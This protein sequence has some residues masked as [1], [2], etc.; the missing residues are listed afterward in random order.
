MIFEGKKR[1][2]GH[3]ESNSVEAD[4][5]PKYVMEF[6]IR[7]ITQLISFFLTLKFAMNRFLIQL[8]N[9]NGLITENLSLWLTPLKMGAKTIP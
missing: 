5:V 8:K 1:G 4:R 3:D 9:A 6:Q 7:G 2:G